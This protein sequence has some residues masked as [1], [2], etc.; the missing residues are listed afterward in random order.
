MSLTKVK[1]VKYIRNLYSFDAMTAEVIVDIAMNTLK[2]SKD[3]DQDS[4]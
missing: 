2:V 3:N 1:L 4:Q